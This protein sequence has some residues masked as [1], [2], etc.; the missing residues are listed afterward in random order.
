MGSK[1]QVVGVGEEG[2]EGLPERVLSLIRDARLLAGG[3]R[4]LALFPGCG[5]ERL[6][7]RSNLR[8]GVER[9]RAALE[10]SGPI[11]VLASGDPLF[12]GIGKTLVEGLGRDRVEIH[13]HVSA[14]QLA[15]ARVKEPWHA[16]ALV[17][18]HGRLMEDLVPHL[19][20]GK[21]VIGI[22][23]DP[24]NTPGAIARFLRERGVQGCK[25][26]VCENLGGK[27]ERVSDLT[28]EAMA[29]GI[30]SPLNVVI[31][32]REESGRDAS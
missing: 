23:T 31:L 12:Y 17:S 19:S 15:F 1:V 13:P 30:F 6:V 5:R 9:I 28:L 20:S 24:R 11:V 4:L 18:L 32:K 29:Q 25:A 8:E 14:M 21:E 3:E 26:W 27:E 2:P 7:L 22:F 16:A 10:T